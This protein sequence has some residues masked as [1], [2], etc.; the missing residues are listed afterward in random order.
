MNKPWLLLAGIMIALVAAVVYW[1]HR[2]APVP[3]TIDLSRIVIG[4]TTVDEFEKIVG[5]GKRQ[6]SCM[7]SVSYRFISAPSIWYGRDLE[8]DAHYRGPNT[9]YHET[10]GKNVDDGSSVI[11][12]ITLE[13]STRMDERSSNPFERYAAIALAF[14]YRLWK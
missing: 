1:N 4:K 8:I 14:E 10:L 2:A 3:Q 13:T 12:Q 7:E 6:H 5:S 11:R 9:G